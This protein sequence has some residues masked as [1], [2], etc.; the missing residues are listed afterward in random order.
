MTIPQLGCLKHVSVHGKDAAYNLLN[1]RLLQDSQIPS[2]RRTPD[3]GGNRRVGKRFE[4]LDSGFRRND[5][6][7]FIDSQNIRQEHL[8]NIEISSVV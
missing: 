5:A 3:R 1:Q 2:P 8:W 4:R 6:K 7:R